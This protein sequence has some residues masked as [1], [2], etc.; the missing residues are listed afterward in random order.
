[1]SLNI[2]FIKKIDNFYEV[3]T[4]APMNLGPSPVTAK[5]ILVDLCSFSTLKTGGIKITKLFYKHFF[6]P[7]VC[8]DWRFQFWVY[9]GLWL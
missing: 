7:Q 6:L 4:S 9:R 2:I 5:E 1:M 8:S 3:S